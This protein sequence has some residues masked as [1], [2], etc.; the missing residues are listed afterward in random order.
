MPNL[1]ST[2]KA[3][4]SDIS[5]SGGEKTHQPCNC[6]KKDLCPL[7]GECQTDNIV[8]NAEVHNEDKHVLGGQTWRRTQTLTT[9]T[10]LQFS[11]HM[12]Q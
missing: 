12:L 6:R 11:L 8:Y 10:I 1:S 2:I 3:H 5:N 4:N 7:N 9:Q